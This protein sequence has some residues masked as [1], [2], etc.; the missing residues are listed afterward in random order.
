MPD[1]LTSSRRVVVEDLAAL[2]WAM[3]PAAHPSEPLVAYVVSGLDRTADHIRYD[4]FVADLDGLQQVHQPDARG[5]RW[6]PQG[7]RLAF[8]RIEGGRRIPACHSFGGDEW[9]LDAPLGDVVDLRWAPDGRR[10][11]ALTVDTLSPSTPTKPYR[12]ASSSDFERVLKHS[13]WILESGFEPKLV[14]ADLGNTSLGEWSPG[15]DRIA[16]VSDKG[17]NRDA[18]TAAGLWIWDESTGTSECVVPAAVPIHACAWSPDGSSIAYLA[19]ARDNAYSAISELSVVDV[20]TREVR[21]LG[22]ELDRS[23][24]KPVRGDDERAIGAPLLTWSADSF[25]LAVIFAEGGRSR[26]TLLGLDGSREDVIADESCVLEFSRGGSG[27]AYSWSDSLTPGEVSW[28]DRPSGESHQVTQ[29]AGSVLSGV[30]FLPTT[31]VSI[32]A[33]DGVAV[34][35]WLTL[36]DGPG[37]FPLVLQVHGG[38]H[39]GVG[40]RFSFDAQRLAAL[41]IGVLRANPRGSQGYGQAFADG[42]L[43]D[44]GGRDFEDLMELLDEVTGT[45]SIDP[46]RVAIIGESY[47]GYMS[48]WSA[49]NS[50]RFAA[51]VVESSIADFLS[52]AGGTIGTTFWNSELGGAPWENPALYFDRSPITRLDKVTAPVLVVHCENDLTCPIS[53]G[54]AIYAGLRVLG[55]DVEF[56]RVPHE[57]HFFN[58]FGALS[59]RL[60]RTAVLDE[61]LVKHLFVDTPRSQSQS[62]NRESTP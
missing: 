32:V 47:G 31:R 57:G 20:N 35:G 48:A 6:S 58:V 51:V 7:D 8:I 4:L 11:L 23:L 28:V 46:D 50:D 10:L 34:E 43:G 36:P 1:Q 49:G 5:P 16:I 37:R 56:L 44:W 19:A 39:Y 33:S 41:G 53:Q 62:A 54:E 17:V 14:G 40:E 18:S 27:T 59:R 3:E 22:A 13:V 21:Q 42:N 2:R 55:K 29:I 52:A 61:F 9:K 25:S 26:L 12:V 38:P 15:G 24:G 30:E 45:E 60:E